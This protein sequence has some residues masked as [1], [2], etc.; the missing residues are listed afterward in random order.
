MNYF[1]VKMIYRGKWRT[2]DVDEHIPFAYG[3]PAF[4]KSKNKELWVMII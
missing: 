4:S 1:S 3:N 2:V